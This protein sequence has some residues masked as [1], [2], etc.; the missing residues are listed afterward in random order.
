MRKVLWILPLVIAL[1]AIGTG[2]ALAWPKGAA[3]AQSPDQPRGK[4]FL[5]VQVAT[6]GEGLAQRLGLPVG[7]VVVVQVVPGSPAEQAGLQRGDILTQATLGASTVTLERPADLKSLLKNAQAGD[8]VSLTL[9]RGEQNL[10][11]SVI[12]AEWPQLPPRRPG[13]HPPWGSPRHPVLPPALPGAL[14]RVVRGEVVLREGTTTVTYAFFG[15]TVTATSTNAITVTPLDGSAPVTINLT[16]EVRVVGCAYRNGSDIGV[17]ASV[18]V[19]SRD[20]TVQWVIVT[21][22]CRPLPRPRPMP[23]ALKPQGPIHILPVL[24]GKPDKEG[25]IRILPI[26]QEQ[27]PKPPEKGSSV[28]GTDV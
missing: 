12:L 22:P 26:P 27:K 4:A 28:Q 20:G 11:I 24:P 16:N 25:P 17:G 8:T 21:G 3:L 6:V 19:A 5:G 18:V 1:L 14:N 7:N 23:G 9:K 2:I 15:G 13:F 10:S